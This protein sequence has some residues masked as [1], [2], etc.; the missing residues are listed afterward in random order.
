MKVRL[1]NTVSCSLFPKQY[2]KFEASASLEI[3]ADIDEKDLDEKIVELSNIIKVKLTEEIQ[4]KSAEYLVR[5]EKVKDK[6]KTALK[7]I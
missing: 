4:A 3:E 1:G 2:E 6:I 7:S 5:T